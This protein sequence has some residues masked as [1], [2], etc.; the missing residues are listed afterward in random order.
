MSNLSQQRESY[1]KQLQSVET[2]LQSLDAEKQKLITQREQLKGAVFALD[3]LAQAEAV[4][5]SP[6]TTVTED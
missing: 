2:R 4:V 6:E 3:S 5:E 1:V